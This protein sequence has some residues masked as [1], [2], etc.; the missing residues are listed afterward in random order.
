MKTTKIIEGVEEYVYSLWGNRI[1]GDL[2]FHN[3]QRTLSIVQSGN[4]LIKNTDIDRETANNILLALWFF[5]SGFT[6]SYENALKESLVLATHFLE[7]NK[8]D[9]KTI[10][11]VQ[12]LIRFNQ[13]DTSA[14]GT[15]EHILSDAITA[16]VG[17]KQFITLSELKREEINSHTSENYTIAEWTK[18]MQKYLRTEHSFYTAYAQDTWNGSKKKNLKKVV[19][20]KKK[21]FN[22]KKR[23]KLKQKLKAE[24]PDRGV[25]TLFRVALRNHI[26]LSDIADTKANILLSVNAIIISLALSNLIPKLDNP[27][28]TYLIYPTLLFVIFSVVSMILSIIATQPNITRGEFSKED[29]KK[30]RVNLIF[31]GNF[32]KMSLKDYEW[33]IFEMLKDQDYIYSNLSKDLYFLGTVLERKYRILRWNYMVFM[34]G[35]IISVIAFFMAFKIAGTERLL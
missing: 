10:A 1:S 15:K 22:K 7:E 12:D 4:E 21:W 24:N 9:K 26:K 30:K 33:A 17:S 5:Y 18:K 28:N 19:K 6:K 20:A 27:S 32:H 16:Y 13:K 35:I 31:F 8:A 23:E 34:T 2:V 11:S 3:F 14:W 25:Q 29:V